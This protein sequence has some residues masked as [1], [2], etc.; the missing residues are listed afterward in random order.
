MLAPNCGWTRSSMKR[1]NVVDVLLYGG[2]APYAA[3]TVVFPRRSTE[4]DATRLGIIGRK[5]RKRSLQRT[6]ARRCPR[7]RDALW[8]SRNTLKIKKNLQKK[9]KIQQY[10]KSAA[11]ISTE[12]IS[13]PSGDLLIART[14]HLPHQQKQKCRHLRI[15]GVLQ[16]R[17]QSWWLVCSPCSNLSCCLG[18]TAR[19]CFHP[20]ISALPQASKM[21]IRRP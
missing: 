10:I 13:F 19:C 12:C 6:A 17:R 5:S 4:A 11:C 7:M 15:G 21:L 1:I 14:L 8:Y 2:C 18:V 9:Y 16:A 20:R 3:S